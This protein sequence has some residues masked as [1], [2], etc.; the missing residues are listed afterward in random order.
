MATQDIVTILTHPGGIVVA[1]TDTVYGLLARAADTAAVERLYSLKQRQAKPGTLM[2]HDITQLVE[3]GLT[4][5]YLKAVEQFWP[6]P[7][8]VIVPCGQ[9]QLAYLTQGLPDI[10]VRIP[11]EE[12]IAA[13]LARTGPLISTSANLPGRPP[14]ETIGQ[15]RDYFGDQVDAYFD[16]GPLT[17][18]LPSTIIRVIDDAI[19]VVRQGGTII[20]G[21]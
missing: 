12:T 10:A 17:D 11:R 14:A 8:S 4:R 2:A 1:S 16:A 5:R 6:G 3:L 9:A 21:L 19:E 18:R 15:A 13:V 7:I 20:P